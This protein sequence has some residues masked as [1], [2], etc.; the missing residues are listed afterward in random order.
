VREKKKGGTDIHVGVTA[1]STGYLV[2]TTRAE[3]KL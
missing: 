3:K 1:T 2:G